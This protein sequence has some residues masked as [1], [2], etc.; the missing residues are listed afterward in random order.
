M[1]DDF[2]FAASVWS[3][4]EPVNLLPSQ[5]QTL[6]D[7]PHS[8]EFSPPQRDDFE[9]PPHTSEI[10]AVEDDDFGDFG[11]FGEAEEMSIPSEFG[12]EVGFA[13]EVRIPGPS[14]H[15]EWEPLR[16]DPMPSRAALEDNVNDI[17]APIW[18]S[19]AISD[20]TTGEGIREV[21]GI[22]QVLATPERY[23]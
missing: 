23:L 21:E 1:D 16:L 2:T 3:T 11:D 22:S 9:T 4:S 19:E 15:A 14:S 7:I 10:H 12:E 13:E 6:D 17:L 18:G 20:V 8:S 5:K